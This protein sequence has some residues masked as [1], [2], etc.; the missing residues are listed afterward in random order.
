VKNASYYYVYFAKGSVDTTRSRYVYDTTLVLDTLTADSTYAFAV[1]AVNSVGSSAISAPVTQVVP[2]PLPPPTPSYA[3]ASPSG[4]SSISVYW[5]GTARASYYLVYYS[6]DSSVSTAS[7]HDSVTSSSA[8]ITGLQ[9]GTLYS[10]AV[11]AGNV[12]G[13]SA[14][15]PKTYARTGA[16]PKQQW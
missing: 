7:P 11:S 14:L 16:I 10:I 2:K 12:W 6:Q 13:V 8:T 1:R 5:P 3:S 4:S 9:A 15:S